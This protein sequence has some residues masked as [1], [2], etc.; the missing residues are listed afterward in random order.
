MSC[1][2]PMIAV[3]TGRV[4]PESK[5]PEYK[6][7]GSVK[8]MQDYLRSIDSEY[9]LEERIRD[10]GDLYIPCMSDAPDAVFKSRYHWDFNCKR[11]YGKKYVR[12]AKVL[13]CGQ[14]LAC[15]TAYAASWADRIMLEAQR[16]ENVYF[17]T[18][19]YDEDHVPRVRS[20][21]KEI[22][23]YYTPAT[24]DSWSV[25]FGDEPVL[26]LVPED[27]QDFM[28]RLRRQQE[29]HHGNTIRFYAVGEYG[30]KY[31][32]PHYHLIIFGL[33]LD[34]I[35]ESHK[36]SSGRVVHTSDTIFKLWHEKGMVEVE[37]MTWEL[38]AYAARYC[39]KKLGKKETGFYEEMNLQ[40]E[41]TRMSLKPAIGF[42][43]FDENKREIYKNDEIIIKTASGSRAV[44]PPRYFDEKYDDIYPS[45]MEE[46]KGNR[47]SVAK[48]H[49][50][51]K[52]AN[53]SGSY[54]ELLYNEELAFKKRNKSLRRNLE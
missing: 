54:L 8:K 18:L 2:N 25:K 49:L 50:K 46:I 52:L 48:E 38:A 43:Y 53:F 35:K 6:F 30:E 42:E 45:E 37:E 24:G 4:N 14:C 28:K 41:F 29:Y 1:Y 34:D 19:T 5:K 36:N 26:T 27:L 44:K 32:R 11:F 31:H 3:K 51:L 40:P 12:P 17:L 22:V 20:K 47:E 13:P 9:D 23:E 39:V 15:R 10:T 33:I 7:L 21:F 16:Y